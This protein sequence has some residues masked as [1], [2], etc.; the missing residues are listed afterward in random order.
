M[1]RIIFVRDMSCQK[2]VDRIA[3]E[4]DNTRLDYEINLKNKSVAIEGDNDALYVAKQAIAQAGYT[5]M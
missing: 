5:V 1:K 4:L 3:N 2:C